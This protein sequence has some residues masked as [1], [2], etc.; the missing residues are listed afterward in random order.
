M[1]GLFFCLASAEG[2]G[3]LFCPAAIQ[4]NT[5][6]YRAFSRVNA[7][8]TAHATKQRTGLYRRFPCYLPCFA[9]VVWRVH[10]PILHRPRHVGAHTR[11]ATPP[12]HTRYQRH[13]GRCAGQHRP[14]IIIMYIRAHR[15]LWI[16]A[17]RRNT[18]QTMQ[19]RR[20]QLLP[21]VD[22]WQVI[23]P[24]HLL[25]GQRLHLHKVS[26]AACDLAPGQQSGRGGRRRTTD[27]YRRIS[28]RAFAR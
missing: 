24:A 28:F 23:H 25:R 9:A 14:P 6:V 11:A 26:P 13:A 4:T 19:A 22:R 3:L 7:S 10:L 16:H 20:G 18:S 17:K 27:G 2:A 8:Y 1:A 21:C 15:L 5:S 12:A